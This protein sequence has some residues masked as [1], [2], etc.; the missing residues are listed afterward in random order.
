MV[1]ILWIRHAFS[2]ANASEAEYATNQR[3]PLLHANGVLQAVIM[4]MIL[5]NLYDEKIL[6]YQKFNFYCSIMVRTMLTAKLISQSFFNDEDTIK[7]ICYISEKVNRA[8]IAMI[9]AGHQKGTNNSTT[10]GKMYAHGLFLNTHPDISNIGQRMEV[11][12]NLE[13]C[14]LDSGINEACY[15]QPNHYQRFLNR[16]LKETNNEDS[17]ISENDLHVCV[18]HGGYIGQNIYTHLLQSALREIRPA[19][20]NQEATE[21]YQ[22]VLEESNTQ[23]NPRSLLQLI[24]SSFEPIRITNMDGEISLLEIFYKKL[25][26]ECTY[27]KSGIDNQSKKFIYKDYEIVK[28]IFLYRLGITIDGSTH[29][30]R[31]GVDNTEGILCDYTIN[32]G[33]CNAKLLYIIEPPNLVE[34]IINPS[35]SLTQRIQIP[36][37]TF[38]EQLVNPPFSKERKL[39]RNADMY[40]CRLSFSN[41]LNNLKERPELIDDRYR[42]WIDNWNQLVSRAA[43]TTALAATGAAAGAAIV[44]APL[45][46]AV[47][48]TAG[49]AAGLKAAYSSLPT[50]TFFGS[51]EEPSESSREASEPSGETQSTSWFWKNS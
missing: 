20:W 13:C 2:C 27:V 9:N 14:S 3:E 24:M 22:K 44:G 19:Q 35:P 17:F 45:T 40:N 26:S 10:N 33:V 4:G 16:Y 11:L 30:Q 31:H 42:E 43:T 1:K 38:E 34:E 29:P 51:R 46:A 47:G 28:P 5:R 12:T 37:M 39:N 18:S 21:S 49:A 23:I 25:L 32:E 50:L 41:L 36:I 8:E 15:Y 6:D 48:I 7:P